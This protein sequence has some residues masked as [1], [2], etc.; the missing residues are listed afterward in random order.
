MTETAHKFG[1]HDDLVGI[2]SE[3]KGSARPA[4]ILMN[5]NVVHHVGPHRIYVQLAR[6]LASQGPIVLRFDLSG[7]GDSPV[8]PD[9][10]SYSERA[11][12]EA[13]E[14]MDFLHARYGQTQFVLMGLCAGA[15]VSMRVSQ[16]DRRIVGLALFDPLAYRNLQYYLRR[17]LPKARKLGTWIRLAKRLGSRDGRSKSREENEFYEYVR[18]VPPPSTMRQEFRA[19][20]TNRVHSLW[21]FTE[22]ALGYY[23]YAGQLYDIFG[24]AARSSLVSLEFLPECAHTFVTRRQREILV[25][26]VCKWYAKSF[27]I[28]DE[29]SF[30]SL[31]R[32]E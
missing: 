19:L 5:A 6:A 10:L 17:Y 28:R 15:D 12:I 13:Q 7:I 21:L 30:Q 20:V 16:E 3:G 25:Q 26:T 11:V 31:A 24:A 29:S 9:N 22:G 32:R 2:V 18:D 1:K 23:N 8:R 14:A 4:V 27:P